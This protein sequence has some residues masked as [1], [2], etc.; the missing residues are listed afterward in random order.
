MFFRDNCGKDKSNN[1]FKDLKIVQ[2]DDLSNLVMVDDSP[3]T[4][5]YNKCKLKFNHMSISEYFPD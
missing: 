3:I 1:I 4:L 2:G 5:E